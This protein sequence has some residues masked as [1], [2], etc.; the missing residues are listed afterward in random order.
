MVK[1]I[2]LLTLIAIFTL[3]GRAQTSDTYTILLSGASFASPNN[4]WFEMGC[5]A[6]GAN[7]INRAISAE[8]I[9][10]TANKMAKGTLYS[11]EELDDIDVFVLMQVHE[12]DVFEESSLKENYQD[13]KVPFDN[14]N[15]AACYDYVIKR[16]ISECYNQKFNPESRYFNSPFGKPASIVLCTHWH[17]SRPVFNTSIRKLAEKWGFP[18]VEFDKYIGF[19]KNAKHPV[20]GKQHSLIFTGDSQETHGEVYG[21]HPPQG[22]TSYIQQRMAA[23]FANTLRHILLPKEIF[24]H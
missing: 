10:D 3:A 7:A 21:W 24:N 16:Y 23:I 17:D 13:Y 22:E 2:S 12:K 6:L 5:R 14:S 1:K 4:R 20:T 19:S 15:Y 11:P 9:A 18:V 8:S